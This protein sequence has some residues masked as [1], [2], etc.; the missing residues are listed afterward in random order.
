MDSDSTQC[1]FKFGKSINIGRRTEEDMLE[2][3]WQVINF[4]G[5]SSVAP[6]VSRHLES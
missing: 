1:H 3:V 5:R 2:S 6:D 4:I